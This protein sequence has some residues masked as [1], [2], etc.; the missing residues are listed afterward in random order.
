MMLPLFCFSETRLAFLG[1][2]CEALGLGL[3][4]AE[5][6]ALRHVSWPAATVLNNPAEAKAVKNPLDFVDDIRQ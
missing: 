1:E 2:G 5:R 4:H 3:T 6:T